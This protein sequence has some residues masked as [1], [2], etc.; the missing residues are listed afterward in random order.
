MLDQFQTLFEQLQKLVQD[1]M[2]GDGFSAI[3]AS[4]PLTP[5]QRHVLRELL[6]GYP[7]QP[8]NLSDELTGLLVRSSLIERLSQALIDSTS[9]NSILAVCFIDLDG[10]KEI[11]DQHGHAVGDQALR[12][13][14]ERI[15]NSIRSGDLLGRWGGDEFVLV[16]QNIDRQESVAHL[17]DRLL[18][19]ISHPLK[20]SSD[21]P[22]TLFLGASIGVAM[23]SAGLLGKE[24][25]ALTLIEKADKAM[26]EAKRAG[27]NRI[28]IAL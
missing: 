17:A 5:L 7:S 14:G 19:A 21:E 22:L 12:L 25:D 23:T 13:I 2:Q 18:G 15:H 16:L 1:S 3:D 4:G 8:L 24:F 28:E 11:N 20:L 9:R 26:Y 6:Q 27:K 10:F